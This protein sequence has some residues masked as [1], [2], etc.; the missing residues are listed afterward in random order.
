MNIPSDLKYT[1]NDEW[2]RVEG[3]TGVVGITDFAQDQLSDIVY[4]EIVVSVGDMVNKG[5]A[6]ATL[7][8]VKAAA[9]VYMPVSG[10]I[11]AINE[12]LPDTPEVVNSDP[13]GNAW[14]VKVEMS[15]PGELNDLLDAAA[16]EKHVQEKSG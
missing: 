10:K 11:I 12:A 14:M 4:V 8:S 7:E 2:I 1:P 16:Y 15:N 6:C 9:D 5:D 13:Y 3:N